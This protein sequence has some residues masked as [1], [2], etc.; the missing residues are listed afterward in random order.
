MTEMTA[1]GKAHAEAVLQLRCVGL[2]GLL[3]DATM[4]DYLRGEG[5]RYLHSARG[6]LTGVLR[7]QG[8]SDLYTF[9]ACQSRIEGVSAELAA[10]QAVAGMRAKQEERW[11][12]ETGGP[13]RTRL[14]GYV[15]P[16]LEPFAAR[17]PHVGTTIRRGPGGRA[18]T[19]RRT[20]GRQI[21]VAYTPNGEVAEKRIRDAQGREAVWRYLWN[22]RGELREVLLVNEG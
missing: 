1:L 18:E 2:N 20:D 8:S 14:G 13:H 10:A 6:D 5:E 21:A 9:D 3:T 17:V 12:E 4:V 15:R 16:E 22:A 19:L 7:A 11:L